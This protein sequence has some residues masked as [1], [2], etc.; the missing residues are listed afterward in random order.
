[1]RSITPGLL[2]IAYLLP[3]TADAGD[4]PQWRGP[5]HDGIAVE[6]DL[7]DSWPD[8]GPPVLWMRELGQGYSGFAVVGNRAY[9]QTQSLYDQSLICLNAD[10]GETIWTH[11]YGW[12]YDGGGLYPG[13]RATPTVANGRVYFVAPEGLVG[14]VAAATGS[15]SGRSISR[16]HSRAAVRI[17]VW[18]RRR[19]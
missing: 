8:S 11:S 18:P 3:V 4:W 14:C 13:P 2:L 6:E 5:Q 16:R 1:M 12:A 7:A 17:S 15:Q 9:T 19:L 10:T